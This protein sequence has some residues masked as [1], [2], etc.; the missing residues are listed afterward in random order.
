MKI[1]YA[2]SKS[3]HSKFKSLQYR[4]VSSKRRKVRLQNLVPG[5]KYKVQVQART[6]KGFGELSL[7]RTVETPVGGRYIIILFYLA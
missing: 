5:T 3:Y 6:K 4:E 1:V 7:I 2:G